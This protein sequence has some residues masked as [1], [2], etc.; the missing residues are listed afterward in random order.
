MIQINQA[1]AEFGFQKM[2]R[3]DQLILIMEMVMVLVLVN[4]MLLLVDIDQQYTGVQ[5]QDQQ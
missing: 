1:V 2:E 3:G 5:V 4:L